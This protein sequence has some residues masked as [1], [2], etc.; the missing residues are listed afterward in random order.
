MKAL[1]AMASGRVTRT[2]HSKGNSFNHD[3]GV[4]L[5]IYVTKVDDSDKQ[6]WRDRPEDF[7]ITPEMISAG[8]EVLRQSGRVDDL[9]L[10]DNLL[11]AEIFF[12]MEL[13]RA[14]NPT[15]EI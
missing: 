5:I 4:S 6:V 12:A 9:L 15:K 10:A 2:Y 3:C 13:C 11:V 14:E 1:R 7:G 8:V